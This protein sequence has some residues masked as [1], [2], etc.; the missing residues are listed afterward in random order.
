MFAQCTYTRTYAIIV[1]LIV[2]VQTKMKPFKCIKQLI[3]HSV[4]YVLLSSGLFHIRIT[5][6][7]S[8]LISVI[9]HVWQLVHGA[10]EL[11]LAICQCHKLDCHLCLSVLVFK[12]CLAADKNQGWVLATSYNFSLLSIWLGLRRVDTEAA[13]SLVEDAWSQ[14]VSNTKSSFARLWTHF[15]CKSLFRFDVTA[16]S[17]LHVVLSHMVWIIELDKFTVQEKISIY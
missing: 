2:K 8:A 13:V 9:Q 5:A 3:L 4:I 14:D 6:Y 1:S 12:I 16:F 11:W 17:R 15:K 10:L 7:L